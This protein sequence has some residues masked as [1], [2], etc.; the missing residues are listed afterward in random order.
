MR[1]VIISDTHSLH[2]RMTNPLPKGDVLIHC[3]DCTNIGGQGDLTR[4]VHWF[5]SL[6][7]DTKI[8]IAGNH[9]W[10][11]ERKEPWFYNLINDENLSQSDC[12]YL[13]DSFMT[14]TDPKFSRPIKIYGTPWQPE[15]CNWAFN[16][17]REELYKY[18]D[19]IP[20][21]TDILI[22]HGPPQE[23]LD[24]TLG[25]DKPG[26]SSL[27]YYIDEKIKPALNVFGHIHEAYGTMTKGD[28]LFVNGSTCTRRYIP[29]N[30]PII[31]KLTE[32]KGKLK[33][34]ILKK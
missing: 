5:Q 32:S 10:C 3:G 8:F 34:K 18:W 24:L 7:Y 25:G 13:E 33:A 20:L 9:D 30:K 31:V 28:T 11:F 17:P 29:S 19:K 12:Y 16:V 1:I 27:R 2:D 23:I 26:C 6:K 4:F 21:D 14:I 22:T 15:F